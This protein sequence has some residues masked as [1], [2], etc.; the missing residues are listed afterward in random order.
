MASTAEKAQSP[1]A[2]VQRQVETYNARDID[3]FLACF[4]DDALLVNLDDGKVLASGKEEMRPRYVERFKSPELHCDVVGR[5]AMG[6]TVVDREIIR[7]PLRT[8]HCLA[9]YTVRDGVIVKA[10]I[11]M[12]VSPTRSIDRDV[13]RD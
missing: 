11:K 8:A 13:D 1:I 9:V 12:D 5:L 2:V 3:A 4:A 10:A 7:G 6:D